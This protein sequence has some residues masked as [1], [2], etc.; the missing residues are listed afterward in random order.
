MKKEIP[1]ARLTNGRVKPPHIRLVKPKPKPPIRTKMLQAIINRIGRI[2][3][4]ALAAL[5][6]TLGTMAFQWDPNLAIFMTIAAVVL[7]IAGPDAATWFKE[8][9]KDL[10]TSGTKKPNP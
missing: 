9:F 1:K 2:L 10:F 8:N 3:A 7:I 5:T 4:G 6:G